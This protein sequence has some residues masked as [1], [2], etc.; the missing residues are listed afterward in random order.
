MFD[1]IMHFLLLGL[2]IFAL[3]EMMPGI[4]VRNYGTALLVALVYGLSNVPAGH[5]LQLLAVPL[6][7]LSLGLFTFIIN[8]ALLWA[9]DQL[10]ED[11]NIEGLGTTLGAA[12]V[13]TIADTA[14]DWLF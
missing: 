5:A 6:M 7:I 12:V 2:V 10:I 3:A 4:N 13:I 1:L 8:T 14:L 9:T 11:F